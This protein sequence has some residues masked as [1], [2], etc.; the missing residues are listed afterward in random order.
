MN[1]NTGRTFTL[2]E[3]LVVIAII[4]V[5][6]GLLLPAL[7]NALEGAR[8]IQCVANMKQV[9]LGLAMWQ[10]DNKGRIPEHSASHVGV[11]PDQMPL[12]FRGEYWT[13]D[14]LLC[15]T[16]STIFT[17]HAWPVP[18]EETNRNAI[19]DSTGKWD[20]GWPK[21][22]GNAFWDDEPGTET[23]GSRTDFGTYVYQG[24]ADNRQSDSQP[25]A[26]ENAAGE[27][28]FYMKNTHIKNPSRYAP[29]WDYDAYKNDGYQNLSFA[30]KR[31]YSPHSS[32]PGHSYLYLDGH[33]AF[34]KEESI[35]GLNYT[36]TPS[37]NTPVMADAQ[38]IVWEGQNYYANGAGA[39]Y[40]S[41]NSKIGLRLPEN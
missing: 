7:E 22:N 37:F 11:V 13:H 38:Y 41:S 15:P 16:I 3:L 32:N 39:G 20:N 29:I 25:W 2:V 1:K 33:A 34:V 36:Y 26:H 30:T 35:P 18:V 8:T 21:L 17:Y 40:P 28:Q 23:G 5:L 6:A 12:L 10:D 27:K 19:Y 24:G 9:G 14:I 31:E 4:S